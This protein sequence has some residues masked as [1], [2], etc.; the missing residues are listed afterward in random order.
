MR[1]PSWPFR[2]G[3]NPWRKPVTETQRQASRRNARHLNKPRENHEDL[4]QSADGTS[5]TTL[6]KHGPH[7]RE[8]DG[9]AV[10]EKP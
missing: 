2:F 8:N 1:C 4:P 7:D 10:V 5:G 9:I 6:A 3:R